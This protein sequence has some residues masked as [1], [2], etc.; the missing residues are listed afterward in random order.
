[1][2]AIYTR[3]DNQRMLKRHRENKIIKF[4]GETIIQRIVDGKKE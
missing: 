2:D 3:N 4:I 1:M